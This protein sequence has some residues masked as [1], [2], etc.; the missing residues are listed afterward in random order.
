MMLKLMVNGQFL[1]KIAKDAY[2]F[3]LILVVMHFLYP[4][5]FIF[6]TM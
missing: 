6:L 4:Y 5:T 2:Y 3:T 1:N